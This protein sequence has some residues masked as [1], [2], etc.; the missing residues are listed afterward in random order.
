[1][2]APG[3]A[4]GGFY[5]NVDG[6]IDRGYMALEGNSRWNP[7]IQVP[8]LRALNKGGLADAT[9]VSCGAAGRCTAAGIY[10]D[11]AGHSQGFVT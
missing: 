7:A 6:T 3:S 4:A 8:G 5:S 2:R 9:S 10:T 11:R 1:L